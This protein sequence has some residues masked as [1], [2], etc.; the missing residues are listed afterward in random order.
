MT[1][2]GSTKRDN[3]STVLRNNRLVIAGELL[4]VTIVQILEVWGLPSIFVL[5]PFG[6]ISLK[7]RKRGWRDVGLRQPGSWPQTIGFGVI[8]GVVNAL[9]ALWLIEPLVYRLGGGKRGPEPV[10]IPP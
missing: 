3:I 8:A 6:W 5:F 4:F 7:L 2:F 9:I 1:D 10:R